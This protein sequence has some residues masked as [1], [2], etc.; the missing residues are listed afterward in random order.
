MDF[1]TSCELCCF[2]DK[3]SCK[4]GELEK[5]KSKTGKTIKVMEG[6]SGEYNSID[7]FTCLKYRRKEWLEKHS[8]DH[9]KQLEEEIHLKWHAIIILNQKVDLREEYLRKVIGDLSLQKRQPDYLSILVEQ[10]DFSFPADIKLIISDTALPTMD[11]EWYMQT[12]L[13]GSDI[14]SQVDIAVD[15]FKKK[16]CIFYTTIKNCEEDISGHYEKME[17]LIIDDMKEIAMINHDYGDTFLNIFH[18][19][20][21]GNAIEGTLE[22]KIN[23]LFNQQKE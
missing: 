9:Q 15:K 21:N 5:I 2:R 17:K 4:E 10:D 20:L 14:D 18:K 8:D 6:E 13:K 22:E 7:N 3:L 12:Y 1:M 23:F 19:K 11:T 16:P